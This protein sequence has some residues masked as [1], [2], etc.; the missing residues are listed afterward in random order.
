LSFQ[1]LFSAYE[2]SF[3]ISLHAVFTAEQ[4]PTCQFVVEC[5]EVIIQTCAKFC[6][7]SKSDSEFLLNC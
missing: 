1:S 3:D 4:L 7:N 2:R 6:D 5:K